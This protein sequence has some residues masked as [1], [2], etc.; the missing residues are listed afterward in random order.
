MT[1]PRTL[2]PTEIEKKTGR[3]CLEAHSNFKSWISGWVGTHV[4]DI[5]GLWG[6]MERLKPLHM[7]KKTIQTQLEWGKTK[8]M[9]WNFVG[10][11]DL[12][13]QSLLTKIPNKWFG[14]KTNYEEVL[15]KAEEEFH[16]SA[17]QCP[18][19]DRPSQPEIYQNNIWSFGTARPKPRLQLN[20]CGVIWTGLW[21]GD[22]FAIWHIWRRQDVDRILT[23]KTQL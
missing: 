22:T 8:L 21:T 3:G 2:C 18:R 9:P 14:A 7:K 15:R 20:I 11:R 5:Y 17:Y 6:R 19:T 1:L 10:K 4:S 16:F 23:P 13:K 12:M